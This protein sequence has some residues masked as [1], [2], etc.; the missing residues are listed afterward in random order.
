METAEEVPYDV[1]VVDVVGLVGD[2]VV[3]C[4]SVSGMFEDVYSL[5][6]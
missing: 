5:S 6:S 1:V 4:N 3:D 2:S